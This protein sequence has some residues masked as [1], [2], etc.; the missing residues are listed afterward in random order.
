MSFKKIHQMAVKRKGSKEILH[1]MLPKIFTIKE[2]EK[3]G[4]DRFLASM[5]RVVNQ[6]GFN[7]TVIV[8]KWPQFEEAFYGFD[9]SK[10][11]SLELEQWEGY[12]KD[13]RVVRNWQ[14]IKA[15]MKNLELVYSLRDTHGS[16]AKFIANWPA[17]D[18]I[19]LMDFL[20]RNGSRLG[21]NSG[22]WFIR[23]SGKDGFILTKDVISALINYGVDVD[24]KI[25]SKRDLKK[26]QDTFNQWHDETNLPYSHLSSIA[27]Y[28][29]GSNYESEYIKDQT[30]KFSVIS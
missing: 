25:T 28:S 12:M 7:W 20:K 10:L 3:I 6:A 30:D 15:L 1:A 4:D 14:N 23:F 8:N 19:G 26:V 5:C 13:K 27:A 9:I 2:L 24:R 29:I 22:Q 17:S 21:G 18:Q 16:F 11:Y